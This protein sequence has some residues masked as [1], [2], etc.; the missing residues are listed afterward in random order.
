M[1]VKREM[2]VVGVNH[3]QQLAVHVV[4]LHLLHFVKVDINAVVARI[5]INCD[6]RD[7]M[8]FDADGLLID[9]THTGQIET[10]GPEEDH[11]AQE[12]HGRHTADQWYRWHR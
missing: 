12:D 8:I 4:Q 10:A 11:Q 7:I 6:A 5:R 9:D 3:L 2:R 1:H